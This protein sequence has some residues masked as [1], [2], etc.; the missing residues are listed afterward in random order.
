MKIS[1]F[2]LLIIVICFLAISGIWK[3]AYDWQSRLPERLSVNTIESP[4]KINWGEF[5]TAEIQAN[6]FSDALFGLGYVQG[7]LNGWTIALWRQAALGKLSEWYGREVVEADRLIHQLGLPEVAHQIY[8]RLDEQNAN[9]IMSYGVGV[10][11]AWE[12]VEYMHE[13]FLQ[14][15]E[16]VPWEPWHTLAIERLIGW[17]SVAPDS[18]CSLGESI[19]TGSKI[20]QSV[21]LLNGIE[22]SS[23]L[24]ASTSSG[25]LLYQRHVQGKGLSPMFQ[26]V[27]LNISNELVIRGA[28]L[29]GT[30]FFPAGKT[31]THAWAVLLF[32]PR[33]TR[34]VRPSPQLTKRLTFTGREEIVSFQRT[35]STFST[36]DSPIELSWVGLSPRTDVTAWFSLLDN[37]PSTFHL[38][39]GDGILISSD[40]SWTVLGTPNFQFPIDSLG[41]VISNDPLIE[42][43]ALYLN[44]TEQN[45]DNPSEWS[46]DTHSL[47]AENVLPEWLD[48][49]QVTTDA[50]PLVQSALT[51]LRN[52]DYD[53]E[54]Q[55]VSATIFHELMVSDG[56]T[57]DQALHNA[58]EELVRKFGTDQSQWL[59]EHV[60]TDTSLFTFYG[61]I[62][63]RKYA[64][65]ITPIVGHE[66]TMMWGG[67]RAEMA[68][69]TWEFWTWVE[70]SSEYFIRRRDLNLRQPLGRY[71][72]DIG[73]TSVFSLPAKYLRTT[74]LV[75]HDF[76]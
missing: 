18:V 57:K 49:M 52:W 29:I 10:Q 58:V 35:D 61:P 20:L 32:S 13:F 2:V 8:E 43:T 73:G 66:S 30:P 42:H 68:P 74:L 53:F 28:S 62:H 4:V 76:E 36:L 55:S 34:P 7:Q 69:N 45:T 64:P 65:L 46:T 16:P 15:I 23:A 37:F 1:G 44:N 39:R 27:S 14:K 70:P 71:I 56:E 19:C 75:P 21:L 17:M 33:T 59:W 22:H 25:P 50:P 48:S 67:A 40:G 12:E 9:L 47:W 41:V 63:Q 51:Y 72:S 5:N 31:N 24:V 6:S 26:D 3:I 60:Y 54:A 38:W 11:L